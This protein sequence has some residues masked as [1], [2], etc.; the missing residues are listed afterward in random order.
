MELAVFELELFAAVDCFALVETPAGFEVV[1]GCAAAVALV[2][3]GLVAAAS[4]VE[5]WP[6]V[7]WGAA[8]AGRL[9]DIAS[10]HNPAQVATKRAL[11]TSIQILNEKTLSTAA[12]QKAQRTLAL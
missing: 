11:R 2:I 3:A 4:P 5:L 6:A 9:A 12:K 10:R 8:V 7:V 1:L